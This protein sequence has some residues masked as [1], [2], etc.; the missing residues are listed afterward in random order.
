MR[1][2]YGYL[3]Y[4]PSYDNLGLALKFAPDSSLNVQLLGIRQDVAYPG[5][6]APGLGGQFNLQYRPRDWNRNTAILCGGGAIFSDQ[7][8]LASIHAGFALSSLGADFEIALPVET[9][10]SYPWNNPKYLVTDFFWSGEGTTPTGWQSQKPTFGFYG[11]PS[12]TLRFTQHFDTR[13]GVPVGF[14]F[15]SNGPALLAG[16]ELSAAYLF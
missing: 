16:L 15:S 12:L 7:G 9:Y 14:A 13:F 4:D 10:Y 6:H 5:L 11:A 3:H 1:G 8:N 2:V